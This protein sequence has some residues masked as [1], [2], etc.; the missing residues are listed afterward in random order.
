MEIEVREVWYWNLRK[1][2]ATIACLKDYFPFVAFDTEFPG[3][4]VSSSWTAS[5]DE[6]YADMKS[7]VDGLK[8]IQVG[9]AL[10][11]AW[12]RLPFSR[13]NR[14]VVWQFNLSDFDPACD[15]HSPSA[16]EFLKE[17]GIDLEA[18]RRQGIK[19]T[20]LCREFWGAGLLANRRLVWLCFHGSYDFGYM[21]KLIE[22]GKP[23]P[24]TRHEFMK[25]VKASFCNVYDLKYI[26][27]S[28][29]ELKR[30]RLGLCKMAEILRVKDYLERSQE[31]DD[32]QKVGNHRYH[33][34]GWDSLVTGMSFFRLRT[35]P[36]VQALKHS[37]CELRAVDYSGFDAVMRDSHGAIFDIEAKLLD[38]YHEEATI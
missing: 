10:F 36:V 22:G 3:F 31:E 19:S 1:E 35:I 32:K 28:Y 17:N 9:L 37:S 25:K 23:L 26:A 15:R 33:Q 34:A 16:V 21:L 5:P 38:H 13:G 20:R 6:L 18:T 4:L 7:N 24:L 29:D 12:G 8:V 2:M 14:A 30:G 11:D 27:K